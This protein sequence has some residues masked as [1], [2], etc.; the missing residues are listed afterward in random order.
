MSSSCQSSTSNTTT[1]T[2]RFR[3][4]GESIEGRH[5]WIAPTRGTDYEYMLPGARSECLTRLQEPE[6]SPLNGTWKEPTSDLSPGAPA[7]HFVRRF[8]D[9]PLYFAGEIKKAQCPAPSS[10]L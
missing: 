3:V 10:Q 2:S 1:R 7:W 5:I 4:L 6:S 8:R 9:G